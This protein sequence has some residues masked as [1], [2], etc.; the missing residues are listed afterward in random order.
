MS[1][2]AILYLVSICLVILFLYLPHDVGGREIVDDLVFAASDKH[3]KWEKGGK[4]DHHQNDYGKKGEEDED[5][6]ES[7]HG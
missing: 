7:K 4:S 2:S 6:Y 5:E 3:T 1:Q